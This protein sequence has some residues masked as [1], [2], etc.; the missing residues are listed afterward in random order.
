MRFLAAIRRHWEGLLTAGLFLTCVYLAVF[1]IRRGSIATAGGAIAC[2]IG[3]LQALM[4][5]F[6]DAEALRRL[7][8][9]EERAE[10]PEGQ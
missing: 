1:F 2:A 10:D 9:R 8:H 7:M 5:F 6:T 3:F 4:A